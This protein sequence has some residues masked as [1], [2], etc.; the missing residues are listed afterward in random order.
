M[1]DLYPCGCQSSLRRRRQRRW[2]R[3]YRSAY[4][5]PSTCSV[6]RSLTFLPLLRVSRS[7]CY[8]CLHRS[9]TGWKAF[10]GDR[11]CSKLDRVS[12]MCW[13]KKLWNKIEY[14]WTCRWYMNPSVFYQRNFQK[15]KASIRLFRMKSLTFHVPDL[16]WEWQIKGKKCSPRMIGWEKNAVIC[17]WTIA[18]AFI[19]FLITLVVNSFEFFGAPFMPN[20]IL[21]ELFQEQ[22]SSAWKL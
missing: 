12:H 14:Y 6:L 22:C 10:H 19:T 7:P 5:P 8:E 15:Q 9:R 16:G 4:G 11:L 2:R 20:W 21:F 13:W 18:T 1:L 17:R 3:P